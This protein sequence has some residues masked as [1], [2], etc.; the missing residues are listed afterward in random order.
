MEV[1]RD[2]SAFRVKSDE[3]EHNDTISPE[4]RELRRLESHDLQ[5]GYRIGIRL[6]AIYRP[7]VEEETRLK[8]LCDKEWTKRLR[9]QWEEQNAL[10]G[11]T[12]QLYQ[13]CRGQNQSGCW[14]S[15]EARREPLV[16]LQLK[17]AKTLEQIAGRHERLIE[18]REVETALSR[19]LQRGRA[20]MSL[21]SS[22]C[23]PWG[24]ETCADNIRRWTIASETEELRKRTLVS[25][26]LLGSPC[27]PCLS[28]GLSASFQPTFSSLEVGGLPQVQKKRSLCMYT[29][30]TPLYPTLCSD[31]DTRSQRELA[32]QLQRRAAAPR[33][34]AAAGRGC[35]Q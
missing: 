5:L 10:R 25:E 1:V 33:D 27:T 17:I 16:A 32:G 18:S 7:N 34:A 13:V 20:G 26:L 11:I 22:N 23:T 4:L 31:D 24:E 14:V 35:A 29:T 2:N 12:L 21:S 6:R 19:R 15:A 3:E 9:V 30:L 8:V 28:P